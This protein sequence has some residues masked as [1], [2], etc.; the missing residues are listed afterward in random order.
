MLNLRPVGAVDLISR[1]MR[2]GEIVGE[3]GGG[4]TDEDGC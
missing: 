4:P 3:V 1:V 2:V